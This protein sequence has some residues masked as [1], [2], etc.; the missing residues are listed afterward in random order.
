M[1]EHDKKYGVNTML[2]LYA[3]N[4][5]DLDLVTHPQE[6]STRFPWLS[7]G[8]LTGLNPPPNELV[9]KI[10]ECFLTTET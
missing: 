3:I 8:R 5:I 6:H 9:N 10:S 4:P 2:A 1:C 7:E